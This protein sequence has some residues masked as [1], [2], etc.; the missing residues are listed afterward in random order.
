MGVGVVRSELTTCFSLVSSFSPKFISGPHDP[1]ECSTARGGEI[2]PRLR[3]TFKARLLHDQ[4]RAERVRCTSTES[5]RQDFS[6]PTI[7]LL[8][9]AWL[10]GNRAWKIGLGEVPS[11]HL[12]RCLVKPQASMQPTSPQNARFRRFPSADDL[13]GSAPDATPI[14]VHVSP[15]VIFG[16]I[17]EL[18]KFGVVILVVMFGFAMSFH[19]LFSDVD[20]FGQTFLWLFNGMLGEAGLFEDF[21]SDEYNEYEGVATALFVVYLVVIAIMLLNVLT[22]VFSTSHAKVQEKADQEFMVSRSRLID[23]YRLVVD[24][25]LLPPPFNLAQVVLSLPLLLA[26]RSWHGPRCT[27]AKEAVG[28][29][30]FWLVI[31]AIAVVG[32]TMLWVVSAVYAPFAWHAQIVR[33]PQEALFR[34]SVKLRYIMIVM[35]CIV[36]APRYLAAFWLTA[37]LRWIGLRPWRWLWGPRTVSF[38]AFFRPIRIDEAMKGS[39]GLNVGELQEFLEDP[40]SDPKVREDEKSRP[41]TVEHIKQLR[42]RLE[43]SNETRLGHDLTRKVNKEEVAEI[44]SRVAEVAASQD[45]IERKLDMFMAV[46]QGRQATGVGE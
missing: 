23:H 43:K 10:S 21:M 45:S 44:E 14:C 33:N 13:R 32:G 29:L 7:V 1:G 36:G 4:V 38:F 19:A 46:V 40:M 26:D 8:A 39:G 12:L 18:V 5:P 17:G 11:L 2:A 24:K 22:A 3:L 35:W 27:R 15:Q 6:K 42:D 34:D 9:Q 28:R 41:T 20:T 37:P 25:H 30:L 31:G 16:M